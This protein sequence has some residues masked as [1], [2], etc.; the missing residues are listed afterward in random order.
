MKAVRQLMVL[1]AILSASACTPG[2]Q[3]GGARPLLI[4][5]RPTP[6]TPASTPS[7]PTP[8]EAYK[9]VLGIPESGN[10]SAW[11][12]AGSAA[13]R[14][15]LFLTPSFEER[16]EFPADRPLAATYRIRLNQGDRIDVRIAAGHG[17]APFTDVFEVIDTAIFRHVYAA[18]NGA[19]AFSF[20][21][22]TDAI[23]ILRIQ[24][25]LGEAAGYTVQVTV[26][27][28]T[29]FVFP[30]A[31]GSASAIAGRWGDARDGGS[32]DHK[33]V[34]IF[35]PRG[36]PVVA[37]TDGYVMTVETTSSGGRVIW[38]R[39]EA[40]GLMYFYAHLDEQLTTSGQRVERGDTIGRVG[41]SGN[42]QGSST[43]LHFGIFRPGYIAED[44]T[45]YLQQSVADA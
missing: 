15:K 4:A 38:Q 40:S 26:P 7:T 25:P 43:H 12:A 34:D 8:R 35:A 6:R 1:A 17:A 16:L 44:P 33:G 19:D 30:V 5:P 39:D 24:P 28:A 13:L 42:A 9:T 29:A 11:D 32:R 20:T 3:L 41:N 18:R 36:T 37:V 23:H 27:N 14:A 10:V 2:E 21:A 22:T 31:G 45:L